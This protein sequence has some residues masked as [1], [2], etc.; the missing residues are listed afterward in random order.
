MAVVVVEDVVEDVAEVATK[1]IVAVEGRG[2][3]VGEVEAVAL[4]AA[5][6]AVVS[7]ALLPDAVPAQ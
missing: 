3:E 6:H 1:T 5:P 7:L 4:E 2:T